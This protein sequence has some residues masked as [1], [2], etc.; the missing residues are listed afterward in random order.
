MVYCLAL[1]Q[2]QCTSNKSSGGRSALTHFLRLDRFF[3]WVAIVVRRANARTQTETYMY[4]PRGRVVAAATVRLR[5]LSLHAFEPARTARVMAGHPGRRRAFRRPF[6]AD[7][8]LINMHQ[9]D[10]QTEQPAIFSPRHPARRGGWSV[11]R[12]DSPRRPSEAVGC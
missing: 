10:I 8:R 2:S 3:N 11:G 1:Q 12:S 7:T 9:T 6:D 4:P 5:Q